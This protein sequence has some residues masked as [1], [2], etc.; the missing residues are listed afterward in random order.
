MCLQSLHYGMGCFEGMKAYAGTEDGIGRLFRPD[1][2]MTRLQRSA[3]RLMLADF[4][5]QVSCLVMRR[6]RR[7]SEG[8][9][10]VSMPG[11]QTIEWHSSDGMG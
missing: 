1:K 2:N 6:L 8:R 7:L 11:S 3:R 9:S 10:P 4:D 5:T